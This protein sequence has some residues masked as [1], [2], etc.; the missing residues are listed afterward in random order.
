M[1]KNI[2]EWIYHCVSRK[3]IIV[4]VKALYNEQIFSIYMLVIEVIVQRVFV[5]ALKFL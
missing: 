2:I 4:K 5:N 1:N 3:L